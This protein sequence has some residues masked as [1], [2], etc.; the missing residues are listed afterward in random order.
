MQ[1]CLSV[2]QVKHFLA[3]NNNA[4]YSTNGESWQPY[5]TALHASYTRMTCEITRKPD[6]KNNDDSPWLWTNDTESL[7]IGFRTNWVAQTSHA[8][9]NNMTISP[10]SPHDLFRFYQAYHVIMNTWLPRPDS[11]RL[12]VWTDTVQLSTACL[13]LIIATV[14]LEL[15]L[16]GR[17]LWFMRRNRMA[18]KSAYIPDGK[19]DWMVHNARLAEEE[20]PDSATDD[21]KSEKDFDYFERARFGTV[22]PPE[23]GIRAM[24]RVY[25]NPTSPRGKSTS[26]S[27]IEKESHSKLPH[28]VV[29]ARDT[30]S[31]IHGDEGDKAARKQDDGDLIIESDAGIPGV[32]NNQAASRQDEDAEYGQEHDEI[33]ALPAMGEANCKSVSAFDATRITI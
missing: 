1:I 3:L 30:S 20:L 14:L 4:S 31:S 10:P 16:A 21:T 2:L 5:G 24:A 27:I 13:V 9:A 29:Q 7:L 33:T 12:S 11:K 22:T 8:E 15:W 18:L 17:Y 25:T 23:P 6:T 26:A 32:L 28:I 19:I